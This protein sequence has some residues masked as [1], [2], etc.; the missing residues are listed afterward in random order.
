MTVEFLP[1]VVVFF[2]DLAW[3]LFEEGYFGSYEFS[4]KYL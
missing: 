2:E 4:R 1:E 3:D